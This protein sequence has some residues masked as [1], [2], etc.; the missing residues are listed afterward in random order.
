MLKV[1][2]SISVFIFFTVIG[3]LFSGCNDG[4]MSASIGSRGA[5]S[6]HGG[7]SGIPGL[8]MFVGFVV[9]VFLFLKLS[10]KNSI[11]H[12]DTSAIDTGIRNVENV[13]SRG[14]KKTT[15]K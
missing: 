9:G 4:W 5:C 10:S 8:F 6:H 7:V 11:H 1:I 2:A 12:D 14:L 3:S 15:I 13:N